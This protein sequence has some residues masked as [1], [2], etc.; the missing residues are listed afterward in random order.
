M[1]RTMKMNYLELTEMDEFTVAMRQSWMEK[2]SIDVC[3]CV[4]VFVVASA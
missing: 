4:S 1:T 2:L 3:V